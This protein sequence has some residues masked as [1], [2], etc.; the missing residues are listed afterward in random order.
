MNNLLKIHPTVCP[1]GKNYQI[2]VITW[3]DALVSVRVGNKVYYNHS[4]GI[5]ISTAGV[6][7]FCVPMSVLDKE[8]S[9]TVITQAMIERCPYYPR[10]AE[11]VE[12]K[13]NFRPVEK[14]ED[15]KLCRIWE[16][17]SILKL[18][19]NRKTALR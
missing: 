11:A 10:T 9:Y 4:N 12:T 17:H 18:Q 7:R 8:K 16:T 15:I 14:T 1:V 6:H 5:R 19:Q 2:M 13:Y 3:A